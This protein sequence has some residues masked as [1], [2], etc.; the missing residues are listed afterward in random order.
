M[1][2]TGFAALSMGIGLIEL[3]PNLDVVV[4]LILGREPYQFFYMVLGLAIILSVLGLWG[5]A[6][7]PMNVSIVLLIIQAV[8]AFYAHIKL[9]ES[10]QTFF[11]GS[12]VV[13]LSFLYLLEKSQTNENNLRKP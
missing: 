7:L 5:R 8:C 1:I 13:V 3:N 9:E 10:G 6:V 11:A 4:A 2:I 12:H